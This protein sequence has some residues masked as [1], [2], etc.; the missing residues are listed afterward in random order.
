MPVWHHCCYQPSQVYVP[1]YIYGI[2]IFN[3]Y[4]YQIC[5]LHKMCTKYNIF[6]N[7]VQLH[8]IL[9][10]GTCTTIIQTNFLAVYSLSWGLGTLA[11]KNGVFLK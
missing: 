4:N 9:Y 2:S 10:L 5:C 1:T 8:I 3:T 6:I 7:V 11:A